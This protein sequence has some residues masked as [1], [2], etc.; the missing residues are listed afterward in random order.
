MTNV[1]MQNKN[2]ILG[3]SGGIAAYKS[4]EILRLLTHA[5]ASVRV[6]MT[7]SAQWFVGPLT[8]EALSGQP[9]FKDMFTDNHEA[10]IRHIDWAQAADGVIIA[11]ATANT[12][13]TGPRYCR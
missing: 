1:S 2:I 5:G 8:F 4:V 10:S 7:R 6:I 13:G 3:V 12:I 9:V 11:P